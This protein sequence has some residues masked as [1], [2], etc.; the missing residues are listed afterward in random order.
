MTTGAFSKGEAIR[1]GWGVMKA[2]LGFFIGVLIVSFV[3]CAVPEAFKALVKEK[4]PLLSFLFGIV[5]GIFQMIIGM[6][7]I[8]VSLKLI[9]G[10]KPALGDL[11]SRLHLF[12]KYLF[13]D[14]LFGLIVIGGLIL[15]IVPG[16]IWMFKFMF[17]SYFIMDKEMG[18][19]EALKRSGAITAGAKWNLFLFVL[20]LTGINILGALALVVGL[21]ATIPTSVVATAYVYRKLLAQSEAPQAISK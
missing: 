4:D 12:F 17:V 10:S 15:L 8:T 13:G 5:G 3:I 9:D 7:L 16:L 19:V 2:N 11:F 18:P 1:Y 21:F 6:G 14:I 20:I